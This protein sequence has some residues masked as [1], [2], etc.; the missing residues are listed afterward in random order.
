M[1]LYPSVVAENLSVGWEQSRFGERLLL[2]SVVTLANAG[3]DVV[4][5]AAA[6]VP[7]AVPPAR[8]RSSLG[9]ANREAVVSITAQGGNQHRVPAPGADSPFALSR[10]I[11]LGPCLSGSECHVNGF[12]D[13]RRPLRPTPR[14]G[15]ARPGPEPTRSA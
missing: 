10:A 8:P 2:G 4:V 1:I 7:K 13:L 14:V 3:I 5:L 11:E 12:T 9:S 6:I 15:E